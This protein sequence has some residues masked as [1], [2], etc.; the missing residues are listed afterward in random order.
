MNPAYI[1]FPLEKNSPIRKKTKNLIKKHDPIEIQISEKIKEIPFYFN[2]FAPIESWS[3]LNKYIVVVQE[4]CIEF[5][6]FFANIRKTKEK[7]FV[8]MLLSSYSHFVKAFEL[9][10]KY[11]IVYETIP[12]LGF[13]HQNQP[14]LFDFE[15]KDLEIKDL[16]IE[17]RLLHFIQE[18]KNNSLSLK[19]IQDVS[20][21]FSL[22]A[23]LVNKPKDFIISELTKNRHNW[24]RCKIKAMY[25]EL[26]EQVPFSKDFIREHL[27]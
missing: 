21:D 23:H 25:L 22:F 20:N 19:N 1:F 12:K 11:E 18:S 2:Y 13:T 17:A 16:P 6:D 24:W 14:V 4:D 26:I 7:Y 10:N 5:H 27:F 8:S 3:F 15:K 9:L